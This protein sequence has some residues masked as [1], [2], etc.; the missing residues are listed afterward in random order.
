MRIATSV[1]IAYWP[2]TRG[3][4]NG[5]GGAICLE[6]FLFARTARSLYPAKPRPTRLRLV[7][8]GA[9]IPKTP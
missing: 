4:A 7:G 1:A 5:A 8:A 6:S 3:Q 2:S 9:A